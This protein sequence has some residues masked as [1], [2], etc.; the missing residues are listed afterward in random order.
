MGC[1][2]DQEQRQAAGL[3]AM[4]ML[5]Q[6]NGDD[7]SNNDRAENNNKRF[8]LKTMMVWVCQAPIHF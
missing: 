6:N 2:L 5:E 3:D 8:F 7:D 1:K 4:S